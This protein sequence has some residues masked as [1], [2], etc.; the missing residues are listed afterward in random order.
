MNF[1]IAIE[2][3]KQGARATREGWNG[4]GQF[5]E[6]QV[7]DAQSNMGLPYIYITTV[8]GFRVPWLASQT[9]MLAEDWQIIMPNGSHH[10][11]NTAG[12]ET[13]NASSMEGPTSE[14]RQMAQRLVYNSSLR[15]MTTQVELFVRAYRIP[16][17]PAAVCHDIVQLFRE[18][19]N[20]GIARDRVLN[21]LDGL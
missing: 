19:D 21:Y 9:D 13:I 12:A 4:A 16:V 10:N 17:D 18:S 15:D 2:L 11:E 5:L 7:P 14:R 8:Q 1:G 3:L 20:E 6:L